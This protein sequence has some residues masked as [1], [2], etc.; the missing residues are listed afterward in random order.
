MLL[1]LVGVFFLS[2]VA[3][4]GTIGGLLAAE[5]KKKKYVLP[6]SVISVFFCL[7]A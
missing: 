3:I 1:T 4:G 5:K 7:T 6:H 2:A